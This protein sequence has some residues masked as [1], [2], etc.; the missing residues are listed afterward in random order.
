M[1]GRCELRGRI[2]RAYVSA[3]ELFQFSGTCAC[4]QNVRVARR[5]KGWVRAQAASCWCVRCSFTVLRPGFVTSAPP[6]GGR[7]LCHPPTVVCGFVVLPHRRALCE[8]NFY[9]GFSSAV[10]TMY[11]TMLGAGL[12]TSAPACCGGHRCHSPI[13]TSGSVVLPHRSKVCGDNFFFLSSVVSGALRP[14]HQSCSCLRGHSPY[15]TY[16]P[17]GATGIGAVRATADQSH[18]VAA[19][20][21][22]CPHS[23]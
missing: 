1:L 22:N 20:A 17:P 14:L 18:R 12:A 4:P 7:G 23:F 6:G 13:V 2:G 11:R 8:E 16:E 19:R 10:C 21:P 3:G 5:E 15:R 9:F